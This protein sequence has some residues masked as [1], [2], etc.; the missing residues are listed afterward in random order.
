[1]TAL[2]PPFGVAWPLHHYLTSALA[3]E[4]SPGLLRRTDLLED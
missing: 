4:Q 1:M 2:I 3:V